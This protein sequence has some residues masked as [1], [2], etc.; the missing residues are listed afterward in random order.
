MPLIPYG[1]FNF[2]SVQ[3][4]DWTDPETW[5]QLPGSGVFPGW[6][7]SEFNAGL[8]ALAIATPDPIIL[9]VE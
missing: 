4:G 3:D 6:N 5:G 1:S 7:G 8:I 2:T 9:E